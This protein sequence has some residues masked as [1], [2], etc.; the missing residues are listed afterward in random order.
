MIYSIL[1]TSI[2][3][4]NNESLLTTWL[5]ISHVATSFQR[6]WFLCI[7]NA[8]SG[9]L[10]LELQNAK[11]K[12][13]NLLCTTSDVNEQKQY[14]V[15]KI[16]HLKK[17]NAKL[18]K[19]I[20][21][22]A[23]KADNHKAATAK[24]NSEVSNEST[25]LARELW[26]TRQSLGESEK[27]N[28]K[29]KEEIRA[30]E[31]KFVKIK[32]KADKFGQNDD[33]MISMEDIL[34]ENASLM[35]TNEEIVE[36]YKEL[37]KKI[38]GSPDENASSYKM[39]EDNETR[40]FEGSGIAAQGSDK[41]KENNAK[42]VGFSDD[43][44]HGEMVNSVFE[45]TR[46]NTLISSDIKLSDLVRAMN[47]DT[48]GDDTDD[49]IDDHEIIEHVRRASIRYY[50]GGC[51]AD[52]S[53][54]EEVEKLTHA[55]NS[56]K[57]KV[58]F[59]EGWTD[60]LNEELLRLQTDL[61]AA[62][63][64]KK[65]FSEKLQRQI[66]KCNA[67]ESD[68]DNLQKE[69][70]VFIDNNNE[71]S[72]SLSSI[73]L[74]DGP[75][76]NNDNTLIGESERE[77]L[78]E[79]REKYASM[80]AH[81]EEWNNELSEKIHRLQSYLQNA[82]DENNELKLENNKLKDFV[83]DSRQLRS[84]CDELED[85]SS[86]LVAELQACQGE[87][88]MLRS[89][90][91][92]SD[93]K[94]KE[95]E[96]VKLNLQNEVN[97][98]NDRI[99]TL[100]K[101]LEDMRK[102]DEILFEVKQSYE[103]AVKQ[104]GELTVALQGS[105]K[106]NIEVEELRNE[107]IKLVAVNEENI[108]LNAYNA[109]LKQETD[110]LQGKI[111][112]LIVD[113][114]RIQ[115][116]LEM[117]SAENSI[118][119]E[120]VSLLEEELGRKQVENGQLENTVNLLQEESK[121]V[122]EKL[123]E[124]L[125]LHDSRER[126][127]KELEKDV[128]TMKEEIERF[129]EIDD[130]KI[131][132]EIRL[133]GLQK[134]IATIEDLVEKYEDKVKEPTDKKLEQ[135]LHGFKMQRMDLE[136]LRKDY[137]NLKKIN[138]Q[139]D[140]DKHQLLDKIEIADRIETERKQYV[141][142]MEKGNE[143][144]YNELEELR[145]IYQQ[146]QIFGNEREKNERSRLA[147]IEALIV[148]RL[149]EQQESLRMCI[150]DA[151][152][153]SDTSEMSFIEN[154]E[155][156][157]YQYVEKVVTALFDECEK[158]SVK[159]E[160]MEKKI[161]ELHDL[162]GK[163]DSLS[164]E[165]IQL[166][167]CENNLNMREKQ[168]SDLQKK[169][170]HISMEYESK[171]SEFNELKGSEKVFQKGK[172]NNDLDQNNMKLLQDE[173]SSL[174]Y[175]NE[176]LQANLEVLG[177]EKQELLRI[178]DKYDEL[179]AENIT[180]RQNDNKRHL[181]EQQLSDLQKKLDQISKEYESK[182][183]EVDELK[184][185]EK[186]LVKEKEK[187]NSLHNRM[188]HLQDE[189]SSLK[190]E[191]ER[192]E[193]N[194]EVLGKEKQ[195]LLKI[196]EKYDELRAE[197]I[198][199]RQNENKRHLKEQQ[200][201]DLQKKLDQISNEYESKKS[202][203]DDL[204]DT[205]KDL[206]KE[207]EKSNSLYNRMTHLQDEN[208]SLKDE[209]ERLEANVEVLGKEKQ[210][211]LKIREKYDEL[212]AE[213]ITMR[214][215]ENKRHLKEQQLT[216]LQK[217]LD[218]ISNEY[219]SKKSEVDDLKDTEK[220]LVK[221]KEKSNS[222]HNRMTHLQ[223][224]NSSLKDENERLEAN[225]E[226]LWK[227]KQELL[228]IRDKYDELRAENITMRQNENK[229][230]LKEQ[231]LSD[232]QK[233]LDQISKDYESKKSEVDDLKDTEK[234][235]VKEKE[236]S[237]SL[238]NC[239]THLQDENSSLKDENERLE[240]NVEVLGKEKQ[241]LLRIRDK[242]DE[243]RAE[244]IT[245][246]QN[247]NKRHLK[248]QQLSDLQKKLDQIS[249]DYESKKSEVDDLKDTEKDLVKEK[250]KSNSLH[251]C[252][253]HLQDENSSLKDENERLEANVEVLGKEN[254][255]LLRIRDKYDELRAE[256]ITMRQN[257]NKRHLK[258]Q[259]LSDL[260]KKLDQISK[261]YES[262]KSEVDD[263]KDTE[264]DLVKEKEKSNSLH[265]CMTHLQD[266][267]SSLKDENERLEANV[268]VLG[269]EKQELLKIREKYDELRAENITMRQNE[270][271]RHLK[272][273]QLSDLQKKLDQICKEYELKKIEVNENKEASKNLEKEQ[274]RNEKLQIDIKAL[275]QQIT[276]LKDE[277]EIL[278]LNS[279]ELRGNLER[280][281]YSLKIFTQKCSLLESENMELKEKANWVDILREENKE[282]VYQI[283]FTGEELRSCR[284]AAIQNNEEVKQLNAKIFD[285]TKKKEFEQ[286]KK[287][288]ESG[289]LESICVLIGDKLDENKELFCDGLDLGSRLVS[290]KGQYDDGN[291][292]DVIRNSYVRKT[293]KLLFS[294]VKQLAAKAELMEKDVER[295][296]E[297]RG[298]FDSV[299]KESIKMKQNE[300][301]HRL[302]KSELLNMQQELASISENSEQI[303]KKNGLLMKEIT[304]LTASNECLRNEN[305]A[306]SKDALELKQKLSSTF[307]AFQNEK[308]QTRLMDLDAKLLRQEMNALKEE[309]REL[310]NQSSVLKKE[311]D[312]CKCFIKQ[313]DIFQA[314]PEKKNQQLNELVQ[315]KESQLF[316]ITNAINL[317]MMELEQLGA[318][319]HDLSLALHKERKSAELAC[320][321]N[322]E[323]KTENEGLKSKVECYEATSAE[324]EELRNF[325]KNAT[326]NLEQFERE[327]EK[328]RDELTDAKNQTAS[329]QDLCTNL[330]ADMEREKGLMEGLVKEKDIL[331][332][333]CCNLARDNEALSN[334]LKTCL[335]EK[336]QL[337]NERS[338][339]R[340]ELDLVRSE[341]DRKESQEEELQLL[342][343]ELLMI[344]GK[345][346]EIW[347]KL[348]EMKAAAEHYSV[349]NSKINSCLNEAREKMRFIQE[350]NAVLTQEAIKLAA[351]KDALESFKFE[352][353]EMQKRLEIKT[354]ELDITQKKY[355]ELSKSLIALKKEMEELNY[356]ENI[357]DLENQLLEAEDANVCIANE[358]T[359]IEDQLKEVLKENVLLKDDIR[360]VSS[361]P[362]MS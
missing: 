116:Q 240:A 244:N 331:D 61:E 168:L 223:D 239:M 295:F 96:T 336:S 328:L 198:T 64:D 135:C 82:Y 221:E 208:S 341:L 170:D 280:N 136:N 20:S 63:N 231:Q 236:K 316:E 27:E 227:E 250:E 242:Y 157:G 285:L 274:K 247:E 338:V 319:K 91:A 10:L 346:K 120:K 277:N 47:S 273:Q 37:L 275:H 218:Q 317:K 29:L 161:I 249:K 318:E 90:E 189:N 21:E 81:A 241:E 92:K 186:D 235:L 22:A 68:I 111:K 228:K 197:N 187:S 52:G 237:N 119:S 162:R 6:L 33:T 88:C 67:L 271:K 107:V 53:L 114:N 143:V 58:A 311:L 257:E 94:V 163:F 289:M 62:E 139:L 348:L 115:A 299:H 350:E 104:I 48:S 357:R 31:G 83:E 288:R 284:N 66:N 224:E 154:S 30:L 118:S 286:T 270:N 9:Q 183:S 207:K 262:K 128:A 46:R 103:Q 322:A 54:L 206:V 159:V 329:Y 133:I 3:C 301:K 334:K 43:L 70:A 100:M 181:K 7:T 298:K 77:E 353:L 313:N 38:N 345:A 201:T 25:E 268:E 287:A 147:L 261:D 188:T 32:E 80:Q 314:E 131:E 326:E 149:S 200:L 97:D 266:E 73:Q 304:S 174:K 306:M 209:N 332:S 245:M 155:D 99:K 36:K 343:S 87:I 105:E 175:E 213:N 34:E 40:S 216:D 169:F 84:K 180:M 44:V 150:I 78:L 127:I 291:D 79:L 307:E 113:Y 8:F 49:D 233:K 160:S 360:I 57:D 255:E 290:N 323:L 303:L 26:K 144:V 339:L 234:D 281:T 272:E 121:E 335:C 112:E 219:E 109:S 156:T 56:L 204:K 69:D 352:S 138:I 164:K 300:N 76:V 152:N 324:I 263:L 11:A 358:R 320:E 210:E 93:M 182:K 75:I 252:M 153:A 232:L 258:E 132:L 222:L 151:V 212:R 146:E 192:L 172:E 362:F 238:H 15:E 302:K 344:R 349:E 71:G 256:N 356:M 294:E 179:R 355:E 137:E 342:K 292:N 42:F 130:E 293:I 59:L 4:S 24:I 214:Q 260:Q 86:Y 194:V 351:E 14:M 39:D 196:R 264:K 18:A 330:K 23:G 251:N 95:Y 125:I 259:Q 45:Q 226:V 74:K 354:E 325:L 142:E 205:E 60:S 102:E 269:K 12:I 310:L 2:I 253:T 347:D 98:L 176:R 308:E 191:N 148:E 220:D 315:G 16:E 126:Y 106:S 276:V 359:A 72:A 28:L 141:F 211:L 321:A 312:E 199:M 17:E 19:T 129:S 171:K 89:A 108:K 85:K 140:K 361:F 55:N 267:N 254:Q 190:D 178:R 184:E 122:V 309:K 265:N 167:K 333:N 110:A 41:Y 217:K 5:S 225:V 340:K 158:L 35:E 283:E 101:D 278:S 282:L 1:L 229:R 165:N 279:F 296:N 50:E 248:E 124:K 145:N 327:K 246:R 203:V 65:A 173:N 202:E 13:K 166:K 305:Q 243:L 117:L 195:E 215:N 193:A 230:H 51:K 297:L 123:Q 185:T 337:E 134:K 177:K